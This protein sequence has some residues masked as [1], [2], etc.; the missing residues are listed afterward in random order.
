MAHPTNAQYQKDAEFEFE[1]SRAYQEKTGK[2]TK[3]VF[4]PEEVQKNWV[5]KDVSQRTT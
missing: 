1:C 5:S 3:G 2:E 4:V